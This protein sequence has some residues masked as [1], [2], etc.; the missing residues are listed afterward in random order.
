MSRTITQI[1]KLASSTSLELVAPNGVVLPTSS[2]SNH[3][4]RKS[5]TELT[6]PVSVATVEHDIVLS[7]TKV[8]EWVVGRSLFIYSEA[9]PL[10]WASGEITAYVHPTLTIEFDDW[11]GN[12]VEYDE[13]NV[14]SDL[15]YGTL[16][17]NPTNSSID[18]IV[19]A[20]VDANVEYRTF[21]NLPARKLS[22]SEMGGDFL[23]KSGGSMTGNL[24]MDNSVILLSDG[25]ETLPSLAFDSDTNTGLYFHGTVTPHVA[26]SVSSQNVIDIALEQ[27]TFDASI[28][29]IAG[30]SSKPAISFQSAATGFYQ[31]DVDV[32]SVTID[33]TQTVSFAE[34]TT[35]IP[36][37]LILSG[38]EELVDSEYQFLV[39]NSND[40]VTV[41]TEL[42]LP[43]QVHK[44]IISDG[45]DTF[46]M[47][48]VPEYKSEMTVFVGGAIQS[49]TKYEFN[50]NEIVFVDDIDEDEI[51]TI[52]GSLNKKPNWL[53]TFNN[54]T[55]EQ[56]YDYDS[57]YYWNDNSLNND[58]IVAFGSS[59][60]NLHSK[61]FLNKG[62]AGFLTVNILD[63][64]DDDSE[65]IGIRGSVPSENFIITNAS[66]SGAKGY[67]TIVFAMSDGFT[68]FRLIGDPI[69]NQLSLGPIP[70]ALDVEILT[71]GAALPISNFTG[72]GNIDFINRIVIGGNGVN[73]TRNTNLVIE[74]FG[75]KYGV[76]N[77]T[78]FNQLYN[79]IETFVTTTSPS[80]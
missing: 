21:D 49:L 37:I 3:F 54:K 44:E 20:D 25:D 13:W 43:V 76:W 29:L 61:Y 11:H 16:V 42:P 40:E 74:K 52:N 33:G 48:I 27:V 41:L 65:V 26:I 2:A 50:D 14:G 9:N 77:N 69:P 30:V 59:T 22:I 64:E 7:G 4:K 32:I 23:L 62:V 75:L 10:I 12:A 39:K 63:Y 18:A 47:T 6:F 31:S 45:S 35:E 71:S 38:T 56:Y 51:I 55:F 17:F 68:R 5:I 79:Q 78:A 36:N 66:L 53:Y 1:A 57:G 73:T 24:V 67:M 58:A 19:A 72:T 46:D 15:K 34:E 80:F 28:S 60:Y 70:L 8:D